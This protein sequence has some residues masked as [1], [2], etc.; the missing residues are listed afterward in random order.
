M[1]FSNIL[2]PYDGSSLAEASLAKAI[3]FAQLDPS[4]KITVI[5]VAQISSKPAHTPTDLYNRYRAA[6]REEAEQ[7]VEPLKEKL[8]KIPNS[9]ELIIKSGSAAYVILQHARDLGCDLIIMGSRGLS[10][11]KAYLGSVSHT[12]TQQSDIPVLLMK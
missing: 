6:V 12:I 8:E 10:G 2:V 5:H 7:L 1:L 4:V 9:T 3:Q 11:I